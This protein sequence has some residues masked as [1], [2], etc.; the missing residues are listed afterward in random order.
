MRL[1]VVASVLLSVARLGAACAPDALRYGGASAGGAA[2]QSEAAGR[3]GAAGWAGSAGGKPVFVAGPLP[4]A[5]S[6]AGDLRC[7]EALSCCASIDVPGGDVLFGRSLDGVDAYEAPGGYAYREVPEQRSSVSAFTLDTFEVTV[8]RFRNFVDAYDGTP[9]LEGAGKHPVIADTRWRSEW[10]ARLPKSRE[11]LDKRLAC[12]PNR[13][14]WTST[15]GTSENKPIS[16]VNWYEAL[17]FCMWE[18]GRA[19]V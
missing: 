8:G 10:N 2:G 12:D 1:S 4:V 16:C 5:R 9:P 14:P 18:I 17:A 15:A 13:G 19:H 6:C 7:A 3:A 11:E